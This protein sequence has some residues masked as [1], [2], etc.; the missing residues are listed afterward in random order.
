M[1]SQGVIYKIFFVLQNAFYGIAYLGLLRG[2]KGIWFKFAYFPYYFS[3]LNIAAGH[4][5][6]KF[7]RGEKQVIWRPRVG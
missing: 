7:L 4:A 3:L 6:V 5:F 1:W 2:L